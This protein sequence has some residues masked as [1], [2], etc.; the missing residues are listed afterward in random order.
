MLRTPGRD[1]TL[2]SPRKWCYRECATETR[3]Q[4]HVIKQVDDQSAFE[5]K[6][7]C[8]KNHEPEFLSQRDGNWV[9]SEKQNSSVV[10]MR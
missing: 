5:E 2:D 3:Q 4:L 9:I 7:K 1:E 8:D 6:H 10:P